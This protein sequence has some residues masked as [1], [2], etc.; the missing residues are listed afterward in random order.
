M[1][2]RHLAAAIVALVALAS[3]SEA[4]HPLTGLPLSD[5][6]YVQLDALARQGCAPARISPYR[7][8]FVKDIRRAL[9]AATKERSCAGALL[10]ALQARFNRDSIARVDSGSSH[11]TG[12][13][14]GS[15]LT[16]AA[17]GLAN[18]EF[19]P[20]WKDVRPASAGDAPVIG[21]ARLRLTWD[22][23]PRLLIVSEGFVQTSTRNDPQNRDELLR[24]TS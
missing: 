23:G 19:R 14:F 24:H 8:F 16:L 4:Q 2:S 1:S 22:G 17:T 9:A 11:G 13:A 18:G 10:H 7:P 12:L 15:A 5:P 3:P 6:A 20:L 21:D